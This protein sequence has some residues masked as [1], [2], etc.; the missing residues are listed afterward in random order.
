LIIT[1]RLRH[2][3]A[4][5]IWYKITGILISPQSCRKIHERHNPG[6]AATADTGD[7][8]KNKAI[9]V[10][11]LSGNLGVSEMT[12]RRDLDALEHA[13]AL[14]RTHGGAMVKPYSR[15]REYRFDISSTTNMAEKR[16]IAQKAAGMIEPGDVVFICDGST[17]AEM[18]PH[19]DPEMNCTIVSNNLALLT[20]PLPS[21][22][23]S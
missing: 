20:M 2:L 4:S 14:R 23:R 7:S 19:L 5:K 9:R 21:R 1:N 10:S 3:N 18:M 22:P 8:Q 11:E 16:R 6:R 12:V 17:T 13:G 15:P